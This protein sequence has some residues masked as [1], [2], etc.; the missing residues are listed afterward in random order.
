MNTTYKPIIR[1][2]TH[3]SYEYFLDSTLTV[4]DTGSILRGALRSPLGSICRT[5]LPIEWYHGIRPTR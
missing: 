5:E 2:K 1:K 4:T 3:Q